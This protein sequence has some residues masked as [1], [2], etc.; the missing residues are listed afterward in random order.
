MAELER[1]RRQKKANIEPVTVNPRF[2][3]YGRNAE[4]FA[5]RGPEFMLSGPT[6]TGKTIAALIL[7]DYLA[8]SFTGSQ[9][10]IVR[11]KRVDMDGSVLQS[12]KQKVLGPNSD[13][14]PFGGEKPDWYDYPNG[15]R[16]WVGGMDK[17][18]KVL[19]SER[20][21]IYFNQAEESEIKD[22]ETLLTRT[23]GRS[24]YMRDAEGVPFGLLFGDCNPDAPTHWI[25]TRQLS[26]QLKFFESRHAD[27]P[28]LYDQ[29]TGAI[30]AEGVRTLAQLDRLTGYRKSRLKDG[31]WVQ[32]EGIIFDT[33]SEAEGGNVTEAAEYDPEGGSVFLAIDDGYSAGSAPDLR[34]LDEHTGH[35]VS[36]AHPRAVLFVQQT[37]TGG[38]NVFAEDYACLRLSD[39]HLRAVLAGYPAERG[40]TR[41]YRAPDFISHGPGQAEIRGRIHAAGVYA[42]Q[43]IARVDESIKETQSW[44]AADANGVRRIHVHPRCRH[45]RS[46]M[47][48]Y[49]YDPGK[50]GAPI[51]AFDHG[52]DA[53]RYL[54]WVIRHER[55]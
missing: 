33:W 25:W 10:A 17:P 11:K 38:L 23:T 22:W 47:L 2:P 20:D 26:G 49:A 37:A 45:L 53:L 50:A 3:L 39:D 6:G 54:T 18:G 7:L 40:E 43:C 51:K 30:T 15:S 21:G 35:F 19:S 48:S 27:N 44:L 29:A 46:E 24:G 4:F 9:W 34:G 28:M 1:R 5:Y 14:Q 31:K 42:R 8:R 52:P 41:P 16:I 36:D 13:V 55:E 32:A 12:F